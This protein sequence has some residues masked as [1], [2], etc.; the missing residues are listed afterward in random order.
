[1]SIN[2]GH[3]ENRL[4]KESTIVTETDE[5]GIITF[6]SK[7]FCKFAEY[8]LEELMGQPHNM[9]RHPFMPRAAFKEL[10]DTVQKGEIWTGTVINKTKS[11]GYYWVKAF[12]YSSLN[13]DGSK[14]YISVR[15]MPSKEDIENAIALYPTL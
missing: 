12:V 6:A 13:Q 1:M 7:D 8:S 14:K 3:R 4:S 2:L 5:K 9:V 15:I 10:W 11:G